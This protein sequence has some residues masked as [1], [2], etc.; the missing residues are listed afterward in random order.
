M[1]VPIPADVAAMEVVVAAN[2]PAADA[3]TITE[4]YSNENTFFMHVKLHRV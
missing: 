1:A 4:R 2:Q 3:L